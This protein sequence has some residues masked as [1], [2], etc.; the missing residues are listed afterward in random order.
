MLKPVPSDV[1]SIPLKV[2][3]SSRDVT[4][5]IKEALRHMCFQTN[6]VVRMPITFALPCSPP[7]PRNHRRSRQKLPKELYLLVEKVIADL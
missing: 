3:V 2:S 6:A 4:V 5:G 7:V 1:T